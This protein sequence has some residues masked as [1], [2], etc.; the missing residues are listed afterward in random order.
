MPPR[1]EAELACCST[2]TRT[3]PA[4][5]LSSVSTSAAYRRTGR[6]IR[7]EMV[8]RGLLT[9][10]GAP[11]GLASAHSQPVHLVGVAAPHFG[12]GCR[13]RGAHGRHVGCRPGRSRW[14]LQSTSRP[15][16]P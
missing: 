5:P 14:S 2:P 13:H 11:A 7:S 3:P 12:V 10:V 9:D 15:R 8:R 1:A 6:R 4:A 16:C